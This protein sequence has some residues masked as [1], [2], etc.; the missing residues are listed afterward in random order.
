VLQIAE[1]LRPTGIG[2]GGV[3]ALGKCLARADSVEASEATG[4]HVDYHLSS[5]RWQIMQRSKITAVN[6]PGR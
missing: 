2:R 5:V 4:R 1:T 6:S 3:E